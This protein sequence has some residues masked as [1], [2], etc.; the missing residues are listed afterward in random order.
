[1]GTELIG[2]FWLTLL[3]RPGEHSSTP[4][5]KLLRCQ[6]LTQNRTGHHLALGEEFP[7]KRIMACVPKGVL[8]KMYVRCWRC[9]T[10]AWLSDWIAGAEL[11]FEERQDRIAQH[12]ATSQSDRID[13]L[14]RCD[15]EAYLKEL[16]ATFSD[17]RE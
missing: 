11:R 1:M 3:I 8:P 15:G 13:F 6:I 14:R 17:E 4:A 2:D 9:G 7:R 16:A 10:V 12:I 5:R